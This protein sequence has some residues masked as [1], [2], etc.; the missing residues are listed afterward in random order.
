MVIGITGGLATGKTT[1]ADMFVEKGAV[2]IDADQISHELL[3]K[4]EGVRSE[5]AEVFED[6]AMAGD[7][8]D[9]RKLA[10]K[11]FFD[12]KKLNK[13]SSIL[14]PPIIRRIKEKIERN[15][16]KV[17]VLDAPLLIEADLQDIVDIVIVVFADYETQVKRAADR[18]ISEQEARSI[19]AMQM[20]LIEK[21]KFADFTIDNSDENLQEV[22]EGV[23]KIWQ[24]VQ[25]NQ[26]KWTS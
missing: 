12:K 16:D 3:E 21:V 2:K 15:K 24:K 26:E 17:I 10:G 6:E 25:T 7:Q 19:I 5:I 1:V 4:D 23:E 8:I 9:R 20:P 22:K 14:H 11:V 13:L 18:G